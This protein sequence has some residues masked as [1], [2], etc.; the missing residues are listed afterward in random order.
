MD[1]INLNS[2]QPELREVVLSITKAIGEDTRN[3]LSSTN[4]DTNNALGFLRG[5]NIN[6]NL[7]DIALKSNPNFELLHFKRYAW[8]G[9]ILVDRHHKY[10]LTISSRRSLSRIKKS[11]RKRPHYLQTLTGI[12]N[13]DLE[14]PC[15]QMSLADYGSDDL[16]VGFSEDILSAD[17]DEIVDYAIDPSEGYRHLVVAYEAEHCEVANLVLIMFDA[18]LDV[19]EYISLMELVKP[20]FGALT[21]SPIADDSTSN[22]KDVHSLVKIKKGIKNKNANEPKK[23]ATVSAKSEEEGKQ[24]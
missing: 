3:Y 20:D 9:C 12:L 7:R 10:T 19:V 13:E 18:A 6:T 1:D 24:A 11:R 22:A 5:D 15:K 21:S 23:Q 4:M 16:D 17:F 2:I 14:A 8:K